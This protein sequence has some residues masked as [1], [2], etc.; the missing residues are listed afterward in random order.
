MQNKQLCCVSSHD[1][2]IKWKLFPCYWPFELG[3]H[4]S[5]VNSLHKGQWRGALMFSLIC[6]WI[7]GWVNNREAG[8][9]RRHLAHYDVSVMIYLRYYVPSFIKCQSIHPDDI[10]FI[11]IMGF[12]SVPPGNNN[13]VC[14]RYKGSPHYIILSTHWLTSWNYPPLLCS[15]VLVASHEASILFWCIQ[16]MT[17]NV[18][19]KLKYRLLLTW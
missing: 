9:L 12:V 16:A 2:V 19:F 4:R 7:N 3:I 13:Y 10:V 8:D 5:P 15:A 18:L 17:W 14:Q 1:D 6:V 11:R